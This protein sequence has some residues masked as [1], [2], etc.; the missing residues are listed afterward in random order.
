M[1]ADHPPRPRRGRAVARVGGVALLLLAGAVVWSEHAGWPWLAAP[2][3]RALSSALQREI[4]LSD[5]AQATGFDGR[6]DVALHLW[7]GIRLQARR[8]SIANA[9]W[10]PADSGPLVEARDLVVR[11]HWRDLLAWRPGRALVLEQVEA[12][13]LTLD[14]R[15]RVRPAVR[16]GDGSEAGAEANWQLGPEHAADA[17]ARPAPVAGVQV[18]RLAVGDGTLTVD[19][20]LLALGLRGHFGLQAAGELHADLAGRYQGQALAMTLRTG[21]TRPW[22]DT[23]QQGQPVSLQLDARTGRARLD[24]DGRVLGGPAV[25]GLQGRY[26]VEGSSLAAIGQPLGVVL[27]T[28]GAVRLDG[29]L[30]RAGTRWHTVVREARIGQSRLAADLLFEQAG[31]TATPQRPRLSG[32]VQAE[33]LLLADLGPAIGRAPPRPEQDPRATAGAEPAAAPT[34]RRLLPGRRLDIPALRRMDA[35][36]R[37]DVRTLDTGTPRLRQIQPLRGRLSLTAGV[38]ALR[39]IDA[40]AAEGRLQGELGLDGRGDSPAWHARLT[41]QGLQLAQWIRPLQR[42]DGP[43]WA[44]GRLDAGLTLNGRGHSVATVLGAADG[45]ATLAW[46]DGQIAHLAVEAAGL[47]LAQGLGVALFRPD[48]ML[49]VRCGIARL[50]VRDGVFT[51]APLLIET[52]DTRLQLTGRGSLKDESLAL[53]LVA[54]PHDASPLALRSPIHVR[55]PFSAPTVHIERGPV[56]ARLLAAAAAAVA[57]APVAALLPLIDL[58]AAAPP[59]PTDCERA[60]PTG[61]AGRGLTGSGRS[62]ARSR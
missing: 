18:R 48:R 8:L 57:V 19:D 32:T 27:P 40:R 6:P 5:P 7:R 20:A 60:S 58:P 23:A 41:L 61:G 56:A 45:Q 31:G 33:R 50:T 17:P 47:D 9:G 39:D 25:L 44:S 10:A 28:T 62:S 26:R 24:F 34:G 54:R 36:V 42:A 35:D 55:G 46:R 22:W 59:L 16:S 15:R 53:T 52:R 21:S 30:D 11:A 37:L 49:D 43:P 14:L 51:P 29:D 2:A 12:G 3:E 4:R 13:G 1:A 38:L